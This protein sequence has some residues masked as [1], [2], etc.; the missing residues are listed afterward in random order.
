MVRGDWLAAVFSMLGNEKYCNIT[1]R[2]PVA[3][4]VL[5]VH[6]PSQFSPPLCNFVH[7]F[8]L[9]KLLSLPIIP[10]LHVSA[11]LAAIISCK[12]C[13]RNYCSLVALLHFTFLSCEI[14]E[15]YIKVIFKIYFRNYFVVCTC[16]G[17]SVSVIYC[18]MFT[19]YSDTNFPR[20]R[21]SA[22]SNWGSDDYAFFGQRYRQ[23]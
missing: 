1:L 11:Q 3:L 14:I 10:T 13:R 2:H 17:S 21:V 22:T 15:K 19:G 8:T 18:T 5:L 12:S 4:C 20:V 7:V 23:L 16:C 6:Y 9:Q